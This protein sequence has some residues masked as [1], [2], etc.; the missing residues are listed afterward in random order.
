[1]SLDNLE[2]NKQSYYTTVKYTTKNMISLSLHTDSQQDILEPNDKQ[3]NEKFKANKDELH[4]KDFQNKET[5]FLN[6]KQV[7]YKNFID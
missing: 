2:I 3:S 5:H 1:M 6:Q 7:I 4:E